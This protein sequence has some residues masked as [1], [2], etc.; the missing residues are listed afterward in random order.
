MAQLKGV[1]VNKLDG[2]LG[3]R[4]PSTD[5]VVALVAAMPVVG[6]GV[7][8]NE[9]TEL[10]QISDAETLGIDAA[11]DANNTVLV[12]HHISEIFRLSPDATVYLIPTA[13]GV[14]VSDILADILPTIRAN[15]DIKGFGFV[16]FNDTLNDMATKVEAVQTGL[17][18]VLLSEN[19]YVD[20]ALLEG[21]GSG[22]NIAA[23]TIADLRE[24][25]APQVSVVI[26]QDPN[27]ASID[28]AYNNYAAVGSVLGMIS[29]RSVNENIGSVN[30][31]N[32]PFIK[33]GAP[34]YSLTDS[35]LDIWLDANLS[36]G[37][38]AQSLSRTD[39][40]TLTNKAYIYASSF[41]GYGGIFLSNSPT[42]IEKSSDYG[43][44]ENNRTW[45]KAARVV[46]QAL[47]PEVK[48]VVK[49]DPQTGFIKS[50]SISRWEGL[51]NSSMEQM[52]IDDEISGFDIYIDPKQYVDQE[53][54]LKVKVQVVKDD[55]V[56]EFEVDLGYTKQ[57]Q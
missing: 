31:K 48:G 29:V 49:K 23:N 15:Q 2:G 13:T 35:V 9:A 3:R 45:N 42:A 7:N 37:N 36:D 14:S 8:L 4:N 22:V 25:N 32:K 1:G 41:E 5:N 50:T 6:L 44:I 27:I 43:F 16:G 28:A 12:Y 53:T 51:L 40:K 30:I 17:V 33:R 26:A 52:I 47:I 11:Y 39:L 46:R 54:A 10:L 55:I 24:K 34:D 18:N 57:I 56:H 20:F 21:K 38:L 19:R